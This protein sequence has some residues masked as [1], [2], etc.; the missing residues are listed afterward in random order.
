MARPLQPLNTLRDKFDLY[1]T[2]AERVAIHDKAKAAGLP[3]SAFVRRAALGQRCTTVPTVAAE[4]WAQLGKLAAN[5][6]QIA[7]HLNEGDP[8]SASDAIG[9]D[10]LRLHLAAIRLALT[11]REE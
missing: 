6:N 11:G 10:E 5:L 9:I 8:F 3:M 4:Q 7:K 1:L 2:D